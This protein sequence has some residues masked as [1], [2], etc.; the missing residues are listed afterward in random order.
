[1]EK[2]Q[3]LCLGNTAEMVLGQEFYDRAL[4][5]ATAAVQC[6]ESLSTDDSHDGVDDSIRDKNH[7]RVA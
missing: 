6:A 7:R 4:C 1:V 3:T 5:F 2:E